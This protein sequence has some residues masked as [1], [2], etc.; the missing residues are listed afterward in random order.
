MGFYGEALKH[1]KQAFHVYTYYLG[2]DNL[3]T[4]KSA[5]QASCILDQIGHYK[6]AYQYACNAVVTFANE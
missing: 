5:F 3:E 4:A 1:F 2:E 6:E